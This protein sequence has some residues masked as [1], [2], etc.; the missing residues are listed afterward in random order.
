MPR[1]AGPARGTCAVVFFLLGAPLAGSAGAA[2]V[3]IT[4]LQNV[5]FTNL[6]PTVNATRS[7]NVCVFSS[8]RH[9][10][11]RV[12][13]R[14]SGAGSAF[15]LSAGGA[16]SPLPYEVQW[17]SSAGASSGTTLSPGVGLTGQTSGA[18]SQTCALGPTATASLI[19]VLHASDLQGAASGL[20]YSGTLSLTIAPE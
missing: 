20:P 12:T 11:Y 4:K 18:T 8:T 3:N 15:T 1:R 9:G 6:D 2:T 14:G 7:Q 10:G 16:L 5:T 17:S 19:V 13:G